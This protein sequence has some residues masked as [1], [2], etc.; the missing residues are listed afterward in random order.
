MVVGLILMLFLVALN[1][2][3]VYGQTTLR[4]SLS[5]AEELALKHHP[6]LSAA[7]YTSSAAK[8]LVTENQ[9]SY[10]PTVTMD[11]TGVNAEDFTRI[12]AGS[13]NIQSVIT[14]GAGGITITQLLYDF[15]R[16]SNLTGSSKS[17]AAAAV[18]K[19]ELTRMQI[20]LNVSKAYYGVLRA[21]AL[22]R[23]IDGLVD[24]RSSLVDQ[25]KEMRASG[26]SANLDLSLAEYEL[27][28]SKF[29]EAKA[30]NDVNAA[31]AELTSALGEHG[32][33][34]YDL[35]EEPLPVQNLNSNIAETINEALIKRPDL[36]ALQL[37][38]DAAVR[39]VK[40]EKALHMPTITGLATAGLIPYKDD[41]IVKNRW[42]AIGANLK[43]PIFTGKL[44]SARISEAEYK[45]KAAEKILTDLENQISRDVRIA[46]LNVDTAHRRIDLSSQLLN[47]AKA[48]YDLASKQY[49]SG[50]SNIIEVTR[51]RLNLN[52]AEID[53]A[54]AK[55]DYL[56]QHAILG[57]QTGKLQ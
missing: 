40:A 52:V 12:G 25:I 1:F 44:F 20:L 2:N 27:A 6:L 22:Y 35:V 4:L 23:I 34:T 50:Q 55:Y 42:A 5:E 21:K 13:L 54:N 24:S 33:Y 28:E 7:I 51:A 30:Q 53:N 26:K 45:S 11:L 43:L 47:K 38:N 18:Q 3:L 56:I 36:K 57:F 19:V 15:G 39:F 10:Y 37:E 49:A 41:Q 8:Q 17:K 32:D 9:A 16:V 46:F 29:K 14:R 48:T 31:Y